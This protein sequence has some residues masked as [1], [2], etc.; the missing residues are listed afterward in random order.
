M[1]SQKIKLCKLLAL[2]SVLVHRRY[3]ALPSR[4]L[5]IY[6]SIG[7]LLFHFTPPECSRNEGLV[8]SGFQY[9]KVRGGHDIGVSL[10]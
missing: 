6:C 2:A 10:C 1:A 4:V 7:S 5:S 8:G 3:A 9:T